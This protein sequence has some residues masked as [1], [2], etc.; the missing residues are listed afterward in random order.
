MKA[1]E[2]RVDW[3]RREHWIRSDCY[4]VML[5]KVMDHIAQITYD[6]RYYGREAER[7]QLQVQ[8]LIDHYQNVIG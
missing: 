1:S 8:L 2:E 3:A 5:A 4:R 7:A 6:L